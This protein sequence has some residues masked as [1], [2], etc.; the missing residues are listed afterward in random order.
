ML[1]LLLYFSKRLSRGAL[2][3]TPTLWPR[4]LYKDL[5]HHWSFTLLLM[6]E[7]LLTVFSTLLPYGLFAFLFSPCRIGCMF[8]AWFMHRY[9]VRVSLWFTS[10]TIPAC[11]S[12]SRARPSFISRAAVMQC[13]VIERQLECMRQCGVN[14]AN[15]KSNMSTPLYYLF[16]AKRG[17]S[18]N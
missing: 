11:T 18:P 3:N 10:E 15:A 1:P 6:W 14:T 8:L 16:H 7:L 4:S 2:V 12:S 5:T 17:S 13:N 9:T